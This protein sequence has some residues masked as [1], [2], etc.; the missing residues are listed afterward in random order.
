MI[1]AMK[2]FLVNFKNVLFLYRLGFV[3]NIIT[4]LVIY[5]KIKPNSEIIPLHYY[6]FYGTDFAG[7]GFF[8]YLIP[9]IGLSI[10]VVNYI[11]YRLALSKEPFAAK[12]LVV[13]GFF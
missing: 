10:L 7:K 3:I 5:L 13:I 6:I 8:I 2:S 9:L 1:R 11:F 12:A 4:F